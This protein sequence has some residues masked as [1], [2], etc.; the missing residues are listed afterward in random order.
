MNIQDC[1]T[2]LREIR[3]IAFATVDANGCP[4]IRIIEGML[5]EHERLYFLTSR[6]KALYDQLVAS[7]NVAIVGMT[8]KYQSLRL[9]G[10]TQQLEDQQY[11]IERMFLE[12]PR[13]GDL[14]PGES[15]HTQVPFVIEDAE[16]EWYDLSTLPVFRQSFVMGKAQLSPKGMVISELCTGCGVCAKSCPSSCIE[17]GPAFT[18]RQENCVRCGYC[19]EQCPV[20]AVYNRADCG[21]F[22]P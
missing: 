9:Q 17:A 12:N 4:Q 2:M 3:N 18:I 7:G 1:L 6:N 19:Q 13:L 8:N 20:S 14:F 21:H 11:W 22:S 10:K 16:I 15:R 5:V